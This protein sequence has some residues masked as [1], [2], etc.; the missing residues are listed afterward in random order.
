MNELST[1]PMIAEEPARFSVE[2][3][4]AMA[5][6]PP[7]SDWCGKIELVEGVIIR[8]SPAGYPHFGIQRRI[9]RKLDK[10]FGDGLD[11]WIVG[12]ELT[13]NMTNPP[14][15]VREPD[16]CI[17]K[18]PGPIKGLVRS[19]A[20]LLA[21]E[22]SDTSLR[23]DMGPKRLAYALAGVPHYWVVDV[24]RKETVVMSDPADGDYRA[25]Q[26]VPF[27]ALLVVP[28]TKRKIRID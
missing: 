11:G 9:F 27:A 3:F 16:V 18:D 26:V 14:Q 13:V 25:R 12:Q 23:E 17:F 6:Q 1:R 21:V 19:D 7:L 20:L 2:E 4:M 24:N 15:S 22:V 5:Q 10:I 28:G 8:M